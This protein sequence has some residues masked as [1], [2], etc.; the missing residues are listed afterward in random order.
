MNGSPASGTAATERGYVLAALTILIWASFV[1][2]SRIGGKTAL[3]PWDITALRVGTAALVLSPWWLPRLL[4]P[5]LRQPR[6][7]QSASFA[8][9]AGLGYPLLAYSGFTRA[10]A[11]HGAVLISGLMPFFTTSFA[12]LLLGER[13]ATA[14]L[15]G[16]SLIAAGVAA[17]FSAHLAP[18]PDAG[19]VLAGDLMFVGASALWALF[20][21][22]LKRWKVR[23]FDVTLGVVAFSAMSYLPIYLLFLPKHV[24]EVAFQQVALQALFQGLLVVCV[25]MWTYAKAAELIG[26][27]KLAVLTSLVPATG[28]LMAIPLL[29]ESLTAGAAFGVVLTSLGALMGALSRTPSAAEPAKRT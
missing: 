20:G 23:A 16:L 5:A 10:P 18:A 11:N 2:V 29:G 21:V 25:A 27:S 28:T 1:V 24:G 19:A 7:H 12:F 15:L 22:L 13:P 26:P 8:L 3:S 6:W 14:R 9:L 17:L 4:K